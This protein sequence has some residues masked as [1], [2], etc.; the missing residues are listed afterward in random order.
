MGYDRCMT[1]PSE[2]CVYCLSTKLTGKEK[3]E[4]PIPASLGARLTVPTVCDICN[5]WAGR[6]IDQPFLAE[7]FLRERR[8]AVDQRDPRRQRNRR[9]S[10]PLLRGYTADG[11]FVSFDY[12]LERPVMG[13]R[14][15]DLGDGRFQIRAGS[16]DEAQRL[17]EKIHRR[18][19]SEGKKAKLEEV[20]RGESKPRINATVVLRPDVWRRAS[21]KIGLGVASIVYPPGWRISTDAQRLRDWM[22]NRDPS[23]DD[24]SVPPLIPSTPQPMVPIARADEHLLFFMQADDGVTYLVVVLFGTEHFSVP[25]DSGKWPV[26]DQ[27]WRLD[28]RN[29]SDGGATTWNAL[30][31]DAALRFA[32]QRN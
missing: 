1:E 14:I 28:W 20:E 15:V 2:L 11:D 10:S 18:A 23:S 22:H 13:S 4:H 32:N 7:D 8:S 17:M 31:V 19:I 21:A 5:E 30:L 3:P 29:P 25:V 26:P 16:E 24:G 9:L 12:G 6:N 27:A